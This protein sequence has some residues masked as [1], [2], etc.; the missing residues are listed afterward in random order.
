MKDK[1]GKV[2]EVKGQLRLAKE[3]VIREYCDFDDLLREL[4]GSFANGFDDCFH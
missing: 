2:A 4:S 3:H 1:E